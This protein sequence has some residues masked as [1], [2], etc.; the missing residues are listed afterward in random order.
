MQKKKWSLLHKLREWNLNQILKEMRKEWKKHYRKL[1]MDNCFPRPSRGVPHKV[2]SRVRGCIWGFLSSLQI[3]P[4]PST[5]S[6]TNKLSFDFGGMLLL[7]PW[8]LTGRTDAEAEAPILW[9]PDSKSRLIGK[10]PKVG[11]D[12]GQEKGVTE[13]EMVG[14]HHWLNGH[15]FEQTLGDGKGQ[16]RLVCCSP[17]GHKES[18]TTQQLN[19]NNS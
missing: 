17:W 18:D 13:D 2:S 16:E 1:V 4:V 19:N 8:I 10:D 3:P 14:W 15:E 5:T 12:W 11:K 6:L 7:I 9:P